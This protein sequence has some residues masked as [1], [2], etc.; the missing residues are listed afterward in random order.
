M[1]TSFKYFLII[2]SIISLSGCDVLAPKPDSI[3]EIDI[4]DAL[5]LGIDESINT[6]DEGINNLIKISDKQDLSNFETVEF[7]DNE[8]KILGPDLIHA[9]AWTIHPASDKY[10]IIAGEFIFKQKGGEKRHFG[11]L[12]NNLTGEIF[13]LE[14]YYFPEQKYGLTGDYYYQTDS[15]GNIYF[16][17]PTDS[18]MY[19]IL[20]GDGTN[21][22]LEKYIDGASGINGDR[23]LVDKSGN[24]YYKNGSRV[25]KST[26][27]IEETNMQLVAV[28]GS[29]GNCYGFG[30]E[31]PNNLALYK[32]EIENGEFQATK[33]TDSGFWFEQGID[34]S[35]QFFDQKN[36]RFIIMGEG[37]II[38]E[39]S[40]PN[41]IVI[42]ILFNELNFNITPILNSASEYRE[43]LGPEG[44]YLW[45]KRSNTR[46]EAIDIS[47]L[48]IDKTYNSANI[49]ESVIVD[50]P[51]ELE[52]NTVTY[53]HCGLGL[54]ISG[55]ILSDESKFAGKITVED[56][57]QYFEEEMVPFITTL[58]RIN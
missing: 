36:Q 23:Y 54:N 18:H 49:S 28:N 27:G 57:L 31:W 55:F 4:D 30:Q 34:V 22:Q 9:D 10:T 47:S 15:V 26:G 5:Y 19:R 13:G 7:L 8:G 33:I 43:V 17:N 2:I 20:V 48:E 6:S 35:Y 41:E 25:K 21:I 11:L 39:R 44:N 51:A 32:L 53:D 29:D 37:Y 3:T 1:S 14:E 56:G 38:P 52:L 12:L 42:G 40:F 24:V 16:I 45:A 50:I 58:S 46:Y